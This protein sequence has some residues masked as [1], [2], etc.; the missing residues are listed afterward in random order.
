M[1]RAMGRQIA[2]GSELVGSDHL[3]RLDF[4]PHAA[5]VAESLPFR[6]GI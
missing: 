4:D 3:E 6:S 5:I 1:G 2:P